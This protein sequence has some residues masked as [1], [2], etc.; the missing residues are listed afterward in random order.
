M[1]AKTDPRCLDCIYRD[2][3]AVQRLWYCIRTHAECTV[4][5]QG[6]CPQRKCTNNSDL[7]AHICV[8]KLSRKVGCPR[9]KDKDCF[10]DIDSDATPA[11]EF[12][13]A[14]ASEYYQ[15]VSHADARGLLRSGSHFLVDAE[16]GYLSNICTAGSKFFTSECIKN[17]QFACVSQCPRPGRAPCKSIT[18]DAIKGLDVG[19]LKWICEWTAVNRSRRLP[20][21]KFKSKP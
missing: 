19:Y 3:T 1:M 17:F 12:L 2:L 13:K 4:P 6:N 18:T 8:T 20:K 7:N 14:Y 21:R 16:A 5:A 10:Q 11:V 15:A 9:D